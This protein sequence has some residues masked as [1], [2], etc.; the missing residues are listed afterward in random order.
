MFTLTEHGD[1][2]MVSLKDYEGFAL[3]FGGS[4]NILPARI[5]NL[6]YPDYLRLC[7][8]Q[9]GADLCGKQ[10]YS[11][12]LFTKENGDR[13]IKILNKIAKQIPKDI[14]D[15]FCIKKEYS[16]ER[17]ELPNGIHI[18]TRRTVNGNS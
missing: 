12:P 9:F 6:S 14:W 3:Y 7:R 1:K 16:N 17:Y 18:R 8:G 15:K 11:Y 10:G 13:L 4:F 5:L 2:Y